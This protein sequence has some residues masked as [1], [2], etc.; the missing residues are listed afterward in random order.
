MTDLDD[1]IRS[2]RS[3]GKV[4]GDRVDEGVL[5]EL[6]TSAAAAPT[7]HMREPW[8]FV[9][10][11]GDARRAVGEAHADAYRRAHPDVDSTTMAREAARLERA[12]VVIVCVAHLA[13]RDPVCLR[14]D[15]DA[16]AASVQNLLLSAHA[17]GLGAM[18]RTGAMVDEPDV[19]RALDLGADDEIVAFVYL[20]S[21]AAEP[22]PR[23]RRPVDEVVDWR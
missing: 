8:R 13:D 10:L 12:P 18:W 1:L 4:G 6:I 21:P 20:G 22:P 3:V 14:E 19:H 9:V 5:R 17:R 15:R 23:P 11:R 2:R 16:V 7:H